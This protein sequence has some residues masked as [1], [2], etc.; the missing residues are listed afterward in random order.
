MLTVEQVAETFSDFSEE[1][2][3]KFLGYLAENVKATWTGTLAPFAGA[4]NSRDELFEK[5]L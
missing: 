5:G 2:L 1:K 4:Y 3:P